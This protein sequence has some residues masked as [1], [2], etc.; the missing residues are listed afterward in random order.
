MVSKNWASHIATLASFACLSEYDHTSNRKAKNRSHPIQS[1]TQKKTSMEI[2]SKIVSIF[3]DKQWS[4]VI[5]S[6][7]P[8]GK[9]GGEKAN[10][11]I[12]IVHL[13]SSFIIGYHHR[14]C[15]FDSRR[16]LELP[17]VSDSIVLSMENMRLICDYAA[18]NV[19]KLVKTHL[20]SLVFQQL[21]EIII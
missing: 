14:N 3:D 16:R 12:I 1:A 6:D 9:G 2:V 13:L 17:I 7:I 15:G 18:R 11:F 10:Y 8:T 21:I 19:Q 5:T 4:W 20:N